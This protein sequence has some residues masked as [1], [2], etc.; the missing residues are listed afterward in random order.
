MLH[1]T[2]QA[3]HL[4]SFAQLPVSHGNA[5]TFLRK[6]NFVGIF[7]LLAYLLKGNTQH[8]LNGFLD[9]Q[10]Q[11][12]QKKRTPSAQPL[13]SSEKRQPGSTNLL[14]DQPK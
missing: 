12:L 1:S 7:A 6:V 9:A 14:S 5:Q 8:A 11:E 4:E 2:E 3:N 10:T 13:C